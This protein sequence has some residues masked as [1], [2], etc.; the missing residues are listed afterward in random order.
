M[1]ARNN[2]SPRTSST[3]FDNKQGF[4]LIEVML[5]LMILVIGIIGVFGM[6]IVTVKGNASAISLSRAVLESAAVVDKIEAV[7]YSDNGLDD[8]TGASISDLFGSGEE[9][10]FESTITY[11][12]TTQN[13]LNTYF[14]LQHDDFSGSSCK[15]VQIN[16]ARRVNG[17][18]KSLTNQY[19][20]FS[21]VRRN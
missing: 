8:A 6:Q 7:S 11:D 5:A 17:Q 9:P 10:S 18:D 21:A 2:S 3:L 1:I 12:V 4:T 13:D 16:S 19:Y 14:S 20:K 15:V